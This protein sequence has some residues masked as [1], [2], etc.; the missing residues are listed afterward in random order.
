MSV[1]ILHTSDWHV[2]RRIRGRDRSVEHRAVLAE[3]SGIADG[4]GVDLTVISGDVFDTGSPTP[5]SEQIV[6]E[7]LGNLASTAPV[8]VVAG[9]HDNP[10]RLDAIAPFLEMANITVVGAPAGPDGGGVARFEDLGVVV[11]LLPFVSQRSIVKAV[12]LMGSDPDHHAAKYEDRVKM[13]VETLTADMT[14]DTVNILV[15]HLTVHGAD[16]GGG[17]RRAH[18]FGY[19]VPTSVFPSHLSY[20]ALGH[21]HRQQKM[22]HAGA[23]WYSGSPLQLDFGEGNDRKGVLV[24]K[25]SPGQPS[26][27]ESIP[28]DA[29][30]RL[31][32]RRGSLEEV[33]A[34]GPVADDEYVRV[35]LE[36]KSRVGLAD[37]VRSGI[38][39]VVEIA[40]Q[41]LEQPAEREVTPRRD[42]EPVAAFAAYL[43]QKGVEDKR[44]E[45]LF[46]ELLAEATTS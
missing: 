36:E 6:F 14:T 4:E 22:P 38:G 46:A 32:V 28:L 35:V 19:A 21:L 16:L 9:N 26:K 13:L 37:D 39:D 30:M 27:V 45:D 11:G 2:G 20:V 42:M 8:L 43:G 31:V 3:I 18:I 25:A 1:K 7:A 5:T 41:T 17:E 24:V 44:L 12:D 15:S 33:I 29:G 10:R 23:V 34:Q 40:L